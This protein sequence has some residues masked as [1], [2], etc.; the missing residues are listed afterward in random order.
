VQ[1]LDLSKFENKR[2]L[3]VG[4]IMLDEFVYTLSNRNSPEY[5]DTPV[6]NITEKKQYLGGCC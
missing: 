2:I 4:D 1:K 3:I 6:L 5:K